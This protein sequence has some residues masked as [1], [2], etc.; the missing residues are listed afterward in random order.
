ML[1]EVSWIEKRAVGVRRWIG[2]CREGKCKGCWLSAPGAFDACG[3]AVVR[4]DRRGCGSY[5]RKG[6]PGD[7][8]Q[9]AASRG[10]GARGEVWGETRPRRKGR[11]QGGGGGSRDGRWRAL[12]ERGR[13]AGRHAQ[14]RPH[15]RNAQRNTHTSARRAQGA[16]LF[17]EDD[18]PSERRPITPR[19]PSFPLRPPSARLTLR[20]G[21]SSVY[22]PPITLLYC[23][24]RDDHRKHGQRPSAILPPASRAAQRTDLSPARAERTVPLA[25]FDGRMDGGVGVGANQ[26]THDLIRST[27]PSIRPPHPSSSLRS[28]C[29]ALGLQRLIRLCHSLGLQTVL[30]D[31]L[32]VRRLAY[33]PRSALS[34]LTPFTYPS[35][36]PSPGCHEEN[37]ILP[38]SK[39]CRSTAGVTAGR[40]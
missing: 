8:R 15:L 17:R 25:L 4:T 7:D 13:V 23:P 3:R 12:R 9:A 28:S 16:R 18:A 26:L 27:F 1:C 22:S 5:R 14:L 6:K 39:T 10:W 21:Q 36:S 34:P 38:Y 20:T 40:T 35:L 33:R 31:S 11:E 29:L 24:R 37:D 30:L 32:P 19:I 2:R